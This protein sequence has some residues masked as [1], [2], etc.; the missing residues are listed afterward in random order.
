MVW[1][2]G[3]FGNR[4]P[5]WFLTVFD[6][7]PSAIRIY[8]DGATRD[9][10]PGQPGFEELVAAINAEVA[11][12]AGYYEGLAPSGDSLASYV[13]RGFA[14]EIVY[15]RPVQVHTRFYFPQANRLL[16]AI[17]GSYNYLKVPLLFRASADRWLPGGLALTSVERIRAAVDAVMAEP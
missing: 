17:D 7:K 5:L 9:V 4:D 6:E 2:F 8:R 15:P 14:V 10:L 16:V 11:Q 12:H 1:L 13:E 3:G